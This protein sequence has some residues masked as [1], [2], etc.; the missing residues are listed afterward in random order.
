MR[1]LIL[2]LV[3]FMAVP[4]CAKVRAVGSTNW[5][6]TSGTISS[7]TWRGPDKYGL[8]RVDLVLLS[9]AGGIVN[10][11][12]NSLASDADLSGRLVRVDFIPDLANRPTNNWACTIRGSGGGNSTPYVAAINISNTTQTSKSVTMITVG[13]VHTPSYVFGP[14]SI[15]AEG[16][17]SNKGIEIR[18]YLER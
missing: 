12:L 14:L 6:V 15:E 13:N 16:C 10:A 3:L 5:E 9:T 17:G 11:T 7:G 8:S 18:F 4:A 2:L 1:K